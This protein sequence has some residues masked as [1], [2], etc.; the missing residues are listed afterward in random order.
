MSTHSL[1]ALD[2]LRNTKPA[3]DKTCAECEYLSTCAGC[4]ADALFCEKGICCYSPYVCASL[5]AHYDVFG[6]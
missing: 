6:Q 4:I 3:H 2:M 5:R 1:T